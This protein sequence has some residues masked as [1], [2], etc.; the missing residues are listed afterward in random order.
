M[1]D[2]ASYL[3]IENYGTSSSDVQGSTK[4]MLYLVCRTYTVLLHILPSA[5][6]VGTTLI[7]KMTRI[8][9]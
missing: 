8:W 5:V 6:Q 3:V 1:K 2:T 4:N 7:T 9:G